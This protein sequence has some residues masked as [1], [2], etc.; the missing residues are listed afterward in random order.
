MSTFSDE[1]ASGI[2]SFYKGEYSITKGQVVPEVGDIAF[3]RFARKMDLAM[4]FVDLRSSTKIVAAIRKISAVRMYKSFL[5]GVARIARRNGG[6]VRSFN[7]DGVLVVFGNK[8]DSVNCTNAV[9]TALNISWYISELL[10]PEINRYISDKEDLKN[11]K[12]SY[13]IGVDFGTVFIVRAGMNG[14]NNND[15]VWVGNA[16]NRAV[17]LSDLSSGDYT[18]RISKSVYNKCFDNMKLFGGVNIW[19]LVSNEKFGED[20]YRSKYYL[21]P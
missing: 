8:E 14:T 18:K 16:T 17:K 11:T 1:L 2:D 10:K 3:G 4:L 6:D 12:F 19:E 9:K 7:G 5:W 21:Q 15:L 13:G 20:V